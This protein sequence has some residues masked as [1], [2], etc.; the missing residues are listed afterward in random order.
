MPAK[1]YL[2]VIG[3]LYLGLALWCTLS[4][5]TTSRKVGFEMIGGS[6]RSEFMTVY[7]GLE[8]GLALVFLLPWVNRDWTG[9]ALASCLLIHG[10]L[11]IFRTAS[12]V[13]Y[14]E[15]ESLTRNLAIGEWVILI[16]GLV[17]W[18]LGREAVI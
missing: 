15:F 7:G 11:V 8:F 16:A 6:G 1:I 12:F 9:F 2:T 17:I 13:R 10:A 5:A 14:S 18:W 3:L 4:P